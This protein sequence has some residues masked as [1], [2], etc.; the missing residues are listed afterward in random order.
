MGGVLVN[1]SGGGTA[2]AIT[3]SNGAY[4]IDNVPTGGFYT[5]TPALANYHFAPAS[6]SF[7]LVGN[8]TDAGFTGNADDF[9]SANALDTSEYFVR[10]QYLDFLGREP[11]Q[12]GWL[13]W[14][15]QITACGNNQN[16]INQR[17]IDVS[18]AFFESPEFEQTG[19]F[20]Y[21][22]YQTGLGRQLTFAEFTA[23]R[24]QV[25]GGADLEANRTAFADAFV[26]RP[27]FMQKYADANTAAAFVDSLLTNVWQ[28][29]GV[30]LS[31][32][33]DKL[34][35]TYGNGGD[36]TQSR[37]LVL[38]AL[39]DNAAIKDAAHNPSFVLMEYFG[40][41]QRGADHGRL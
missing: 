17:R 36:Q 33:R 20:I 15:N 41:L 2:R 19:S 32:Q 1:L 3:N 13:Y 24:P 8:Q 27:E 7:S 39:S 4:R 23:D 16:C 26:A 38:R 18:A 37:S 21:R 14:T 34:V 25:L 6:R 12:G 29:S 30:D 22:L 5:V 28:S 35:A 40:Y 11:D 10:Q 9:A 31:S